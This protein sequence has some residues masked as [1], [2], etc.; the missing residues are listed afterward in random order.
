MKILAHKQTTT[1]E[2]VEHEV[3][4]PVYVKYDYAGESCVVLQITKVLANGKTYSLKRTWMYRVPTYEFTHKFRALATYLPD[5]LAGNG[6]SS[7][8]TEQEWEALLDD[9]KATFAQF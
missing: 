6:D 5:F 9:F 3:E 2:L 8:A 1:S 7:M 4:F